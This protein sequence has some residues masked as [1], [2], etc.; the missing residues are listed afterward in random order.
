M[1]VH[2]FTPE[3][4][5]RRISLLFAICR[6]SYHQ[7]TH[8]HIEKGDKKESLSKY[9]GKYLW[10]IYNTSGVSHLRVAQFHPT[11]FAIIMKVGRGKGNGWTGKR[12]KDI[13]EKRSDWETLAL[14][15]E[16]I[17][18][19]IFGHSQTQ[20]TISLHFR[21]MCAPCLLCYPWT[22][23]GRKHLQ[24]GKATGIRIMQKS[25]GGICFHLFWRRSFERERLVRLS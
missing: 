1:K 23:P 13:K 21:F 25:V 5:R 15:V 11:V 17:S 22:E 2:N 16:N 20:H 12:T 10:N 6:W 19:G 7:Y 18:S 24:I 3:P 14:V 9:E 8:T 4:W